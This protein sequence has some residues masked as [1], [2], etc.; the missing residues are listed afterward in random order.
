MRA[1]SYLP[2]TLTIVFAVTSGYLVVSNWWPMTHQGDVNMVQRLREQHERQ[3]TL[4]APTPSQ[5]PVK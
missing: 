1:S 4:V 2:W 3:F 5:L